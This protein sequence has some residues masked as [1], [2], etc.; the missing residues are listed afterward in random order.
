MANL[1][2]KVQGAVEALKEKG[3]EVDVHVKGGTIRSQFLEI[4]AVLGGSEHNDIDCAA[5]I[6]KALRDAVGYGTFANSYDP[7]TKMM[8]ASY[9]PLAKESSVVRTVSKVTV[10][11]GRCVS[12][13]AERVRSAGSTPEY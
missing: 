4:T 7:R 9:R 13:T 3:I 12:R 11:A 10:S 6:Q 2:E 5:E 8:T 1:G